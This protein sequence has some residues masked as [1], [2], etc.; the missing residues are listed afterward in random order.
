MR[1]Y[2]RRMARRK[3]GFKRP[4]RF[5]MVPRL[6]VPERALVS[7]RY[8]QTVGTTLDN[9]NSVL[10][11]F[12]TFRAN[13]IFDPD[14]TGLGHQPAGYDELANF[15]RYYRVVGLKYNIK[16]KVAVDLEE[17]DLFYYGVDCM[18][19]HGQTTTEFQAFLM[20]ELKESAPYRQWTTVN[21]N[22]DYK[23][24]KGYVSPAKILGMSKEQYRTSDSTWSLWTTN[25]VFQTYLTVCLSG[26][27]SLSATDSLDVFADVQLTYLVEC[28][29]RFI[30]PTS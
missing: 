8:S 25:P 1:P 28:S 9:T 21:A 17:I 16:F 26:I 7:M 30:L 15:Y 23:S 14:Q 24:I 5:Q 2:R 6:V 29:N 4:P 11:N 19:L 12:Q 3:T 27:T 13:S 22:Q 18:V 10:L 20:N